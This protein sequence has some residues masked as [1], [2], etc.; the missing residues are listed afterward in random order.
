MKPS[1]AGIIIMAAGSSSRLGKPKQLLKYQ[2]KSL[3]QRAIETADKTD[4]QMSV[5]ILGANLELILKEIRG[6]KVNV[7]INNSWQEGMSSG[8][9][10][11]LDYLEK[12][13][14]PDLVILMLCDQPF[15]DSDVL[16]LLIE[17]QKATGKGIIAC[18]YDEVV[19]VPALFTK[20]YFPKLR[21]LKGTEGAKKVLYDNQDDL[22]HIDFQDAAIDIDTMEDYEKLTNGKY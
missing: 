8:M 19:G 5:L 6:L 16:N 10:K 15:V 13:L 14:D 21:K 20:K 17:K 7:V 9:Q 2:G 18:Q 4:S 12:K 1:K 3:I 22:A 11:G